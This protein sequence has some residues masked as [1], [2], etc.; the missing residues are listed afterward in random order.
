MGKYLIITVLLVII[1]FGIEIAGSIL[2]RSFYNQLIQAIG[3]NDQKEF[4]RI[5]NKKIVRFLIPRYDMEYL[6]LNLILSNGNKK[7]INEQFR[8]VINSSSNITQ[9]TDILMTAFDHYVSNGDKEMSKV[10]AKE[11]TALNN[12]ELSNYVKRLYDIKI[13]RSGKYLDE[14]LEEIDREDV[15][16]IWQKEMLVSLIYEHQGNKQLCEEYKQLSKE[17]F[18]REINLK[19][20]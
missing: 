10:Y 2:K 18:E 5:S 20:G 16:N 17:H 12:Q 7:E 11:I 6:R 19:G 14:I 4:E 15:R 8:N 3:S 9:K 1:T 13:N